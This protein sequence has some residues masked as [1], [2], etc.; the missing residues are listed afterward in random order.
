MAVSRLPDGRGL[1]R[2]EEPGD[3][4]PTD[5]LRR[6]LR[7]GRSGPR[8]ES[9]PALVA[10]EGLRLTETAGELHHPRRLAGGA[11]EEEEGPT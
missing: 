7:D 8:G 2:G 5:Q 1:D 3:L 10:V 11:R 9:Q 4:E 6:V